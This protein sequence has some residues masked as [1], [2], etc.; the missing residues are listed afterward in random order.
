MSA[1]AFEQWVF[2]PAPRD[3]VLIDGTTPGVVRAVSTKYG[4]ALVGPDGDT[5][6]YSISIDRLTKEDPST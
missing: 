2:T 1:P 5:D 4:K 3:R 6:S